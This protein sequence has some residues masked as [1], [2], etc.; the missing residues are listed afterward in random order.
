MTCVGLTALDLTRT[1]GAW[2]TLGPFWSA[3]PHLHSPIGGLW[4]RCVDLCRHMKKLYSIRFGEK[5]AFEAWFCLSQ[6]A[7]R[8]VIDYRQGC[9]TCTTSSSLSDR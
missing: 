5:R 1:I 7:C 8:T 6:D 2:W 9:N 4:R 3:L